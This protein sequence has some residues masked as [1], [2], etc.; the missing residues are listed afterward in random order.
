METS[1]SPNMLTKV[2]NIDGSCSMVNFAANIKYMTTMK[3]PIHNIPIRM[4]FMIKDYFTFF[5]NVNS[6]ES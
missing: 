5:E 1:V 2:A 4:P 6:P 3:A